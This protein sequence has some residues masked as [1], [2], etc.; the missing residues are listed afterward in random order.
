MHSNG[1]K[2]LI[3]QKSQLQNPRTG[4][5][6]DLSRRRIFQGAKPQFIINSSAARPIV[7][8][9]SHF[10][11]SPDRR[12]AAVARRHFV[13]TTLLLPTAGIHSS[14]GFT[15]ITSHKPERVQWDC[16]M[17]AAWPHHSDPN[18]RQQQE[19]TDRRQTSP[20]TLHMVFHSFALQLQYAVMQLGSQLQV[21]L[22]SN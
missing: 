18:A 19:V 2:G 16:C 12:T 15:S 6:W 10:P 7:Y 20:N 5:K 4:S 11:I 22:F 14:C 21:K 1:A 8:A 13:M 17:C 9:W 3:H